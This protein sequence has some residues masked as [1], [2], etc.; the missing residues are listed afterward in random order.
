M[1]S[2]RHLRDSYGGVRFAHYASVTSRVTVE[3]VD[4]QRTRALHAETLPKGHK[5]L[6]KSL[7]AALLSGTV[8]LGATGVAYATTA[9][10]HA[11]THQTNSSA[12]KTK[13]GEHCT[14]HSKN[15]TSKA[16]SGTEKTKRGDTCT[17]ASKAVRSGNEA[18]IKT[19]GDDSS[20]TTT[21][22]AG[23][24]SDTNSWR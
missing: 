20:S 7:L 18:N 1:I 15:R 4:I 14:E 5:M 2:R 22:R 23:K 9:A 16:R 19:G 8:S 13:D 6:T 12:S 21:P 11:R 24:R 17:D 3:L 10:G